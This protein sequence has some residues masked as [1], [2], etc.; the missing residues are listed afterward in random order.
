MVAK[1]AQGDVVVNA[2]FHHTIRATNY[3]F[4]NGTSRIQLVGA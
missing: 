1:N 3:Q 2:P 4:D